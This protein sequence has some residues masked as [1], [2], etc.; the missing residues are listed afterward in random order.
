MNQEIIKK[1]I[2]SQYNFK[3]ITFFDL[4]QSKGDR[5]VYKFII[6]GNAYVVKI[7]SP[8]KTSAEMEKDTYF[9]DFSKQSNFNHVQALIKTKDNSN[10]IKLDNRFLYI[11]EYLDGT[12]P[13]NSKQNWA[14]I[15]KITA[16][17]HKLKSY[18][19]QSGLDPNNEKRVILDSKLIPNSIKQEYDLLVKN[20]P[21]FKNNKKTIIHTDIGLHNAVD[22]GGEIFFIDWDDVGIGYSVLDIGYPLLTQLVSSTYEFD[23]ESAKSFYE[24]YFSNIDDQENPTVE[25]IFD[26]SLLFLLMY[27]PFADNLDTGWLKI[28]YVL[29]NRDMFESFL[30]TILNK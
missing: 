3:E 13:S 6:D 11:L 16:E 18:M 25:D 23:R 14:K 24:A 17:L 7:S 12:N 2:L 9:F 28:K 19:Y 1:H 27:L 30:R 29:D 8:E 5:Y 20:L 15:G 10:Y 21:D 26:A 22:V 4:L